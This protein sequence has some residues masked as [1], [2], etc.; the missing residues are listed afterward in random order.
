MFVPTPEQKNKA[1]KNVLS[2]LKCDA[3]WQK[4]HRDISY[5]NTVGCDFGRHGFLILQL[6]LA[7][8]GDVK[9][10]ACRTVLEEIKYSQNML[11]EEFAK[12][13]KKQHQHEAARLA[14]T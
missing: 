12:L 13:R 7:A 1:V 6:I 14:K 3:R 4:I 10:F 2:Q 11:E 8:G 5:N 9:C